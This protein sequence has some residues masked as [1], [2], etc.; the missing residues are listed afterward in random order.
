M[1]TMFSVP[2]PFRHHIGII[3]RNAVQSWTLIRPR[4]EIILFGDDEGTAE[5]AKS[6]GVRHVP[7]VA[8]NEYGTPLLN[9]PFEQAKRLATYDLLCYVNADIILMSDFLEAVRRIVRWKHRFLMVGR[10][11]DIDIKEYVDFTMGWENRLR[12]RVNCQ[13]Q[14]HPST[15]IDYFVFPRRM[16]GDIPPLAIGRTTWDNWLIYQARAM[17][18]PMID[19][20][21]SIMAVHQNHDYLH[22]P[23][24]GGDAWEGPEAKRNLQL[25]GG[26][27]HVFTL[28]DAT[29]TLG[30]DSPRPTLSRRHLQRRLQT[31]PCLYPYLRFLAIFMKAFIRVSGSLRWASKKNCPAK[32]VRL[33]AKQ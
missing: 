27:G 25:A 26:R 22:I 15:G 20:T 5:V 6:F 21:D 29:Y 9:D 19:A 24:R 8:R 30:Q 2:K 14:L 28:K 11:W 16:W 10:R 4:P 33:D 1:I 23:A 3:Q 13:G 7:K 17:H 32:E 12:A 31:L 18:V